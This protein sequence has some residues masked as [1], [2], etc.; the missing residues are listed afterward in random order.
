MKL[1]IKT[2]F[3]SVLAVWL[4]GCYGDLG[5]DVPWE[6]D[7]EVALE[8]DGGSALVRTFSTTYGFNVVI[9]SHM[10]RQGVTIDVAYRLDSD[11]SLVFDQTYTATASPQPVTI[12]NIPFNEVGT[13]TVTVTS[14]T[15]A[16][17]TVTKT[18]KLVRK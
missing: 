4:T 16:D 14:L 17:N 12:T 18:F 9:L 6:Q 1:F 13:V 11:N 3:V 7:L 15:R 5:D 2:L 8:P 10:P